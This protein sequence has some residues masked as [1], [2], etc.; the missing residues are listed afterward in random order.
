M[1]SR[2]TT[3]C[4]R[5]WRIWPSSTQQAFRGARW[6]SRWPSDAF[7][8]GVIQRTPVPD[9]TPADEA[10][11]ASLARRAW[12]LKRSLDTRTE[13]SHA[14]VL[15]ALL[16]IEGRTL[17]ARSA[18]WTE[19]VQAV[20]AELAAIQAEID[21]RCFTLYGIDEEDR[22]AITEGFG[23]SS[24]DAEARRGRRGRRRR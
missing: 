20:E 6:N 12:S 13:T 10:A 3:I 14:F 17:A 22:R 23:G 15:P 11:L 24:P 2:R 1:L 7:E 5:C 4:R 21:E 8:V 9:L 16:Q 19:H 18:A